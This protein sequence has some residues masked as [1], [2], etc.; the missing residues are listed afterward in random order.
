MIWDSQTV[1][2]RKTLHETPLDILY[3]TLTIMGW[4]RKYNEPM[5]H[6]MEVQIFLNLPHMAFLQRYW[7]LKI[8]NH[9]GV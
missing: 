6:K 1:L 3:Q 2:L 8:Q 9:D 4:N 7:S 5:T